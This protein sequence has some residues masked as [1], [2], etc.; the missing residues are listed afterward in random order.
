MI[1]TAFTLERAVQHPRSMSRA[2]RA[3][4]FMLPFVVLSGLAKYAPFFGTSPAASIEA[5]EVPA[6][7]EMQ[8]PAVVP[9]DDD[10][11]RTEPLDL[12]SELSKIT[13]AAR[14]EVAEK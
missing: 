13:S 3:L 12:V 4:L 6:V 8:A 1:A 2:E 7:V 5:R 9:V 14:V 11:L 10:E